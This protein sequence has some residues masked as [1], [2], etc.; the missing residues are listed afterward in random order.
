MGWVTSKGEEHREDGQP[1]ETLCYDT[2]VRREMGCWLQG[3][4]GLRVLV[5]VGFLY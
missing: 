3:T 2:E 1:S 4:G 5:F